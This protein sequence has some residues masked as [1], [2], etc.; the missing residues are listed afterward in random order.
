M[1]EE[2]FS[3]AKASILVELGDFAIEL[4]EDGAKGAPQVIV[5]TE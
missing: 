4:I 1:V 3:G 2:G 5:V